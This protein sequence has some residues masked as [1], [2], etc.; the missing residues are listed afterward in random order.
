MDDDSEDEKDTSFYQNK[1][2]SE[3]EEFSPNDLYFE[4]EQFMRL[5]TQHVFNFPPNGDKLFLPLCEVFVRRYS[6]II[7][8][9][10]LRYCALFHF[11]HMWKIGLLAFNDICSIMKFIDD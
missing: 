8:E 11:I 1:I 6:N 5:W 3:L 4:E 2:L 9:K 7:I 10:N